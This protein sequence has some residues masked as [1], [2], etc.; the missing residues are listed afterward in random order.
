MCEYCWSD[1]DEEDSPYEEDEPE[2]EASSV[3]NWPEGAEYEVSVRGK[4]GRT[5][6]RMQVDDEY[7]EFGTISSGTRFA[8]SSRRQTIEVPY[9]AQV[10]YRLIIPEW[11]RGDVVVETT[12]PKLTWLRMSEDAWQ[13]D[14]LNMAFVDD[15]AMNDC[16]VK[17]E[18]RHVLRDGKA[19]A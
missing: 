16:Y 3:T 5:D 19:V 6:I 17:G 13:S 2:Q 12:V 18:I 15:E 7:E 8:P 11:K 14:N 10:T 9:G 4:V 1:R